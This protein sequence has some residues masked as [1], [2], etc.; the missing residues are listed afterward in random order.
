MKGSRVELER[1]E[2]RSDRFKA[3]CKELVAAKKASFDRIVAAK[4]KAEA[5]RGE[6]LD[7]AAKTAPSPTSL[8]KSCAEECR[9]EAA[10]PKPVGGRSLTGT[11]DQAA[12]TI[13]APAPV[14][15]LAAGPSATG[16][17]EQ[18]ATTVEAPAAK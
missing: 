11:V 13:E 17:V 1:A 14:P 4:D 9:E 8:L 6:W 12:T 5:A 3:E 7:K 10:A 2:K 16:T 18:A 15:K